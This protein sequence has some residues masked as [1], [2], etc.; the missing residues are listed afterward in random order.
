[1][2]IAIALLGLNLP[3]AGYA[4]T[5]NSPIVEKG[6]P[7][8]EYQ[9]DYNR[10][11]D[12][13]VN[14]SSNHKVEVGFGITDRWSTA[15][16]GIYVAQPGGG[17]TYDRF[18]WENTY[19]LFDQGEHWLDAGLYIE[20]QAP[21]AK[22]RL[23]DVLEFQVLLQKSVAGND[24]LPSRTASATMDAYSSIARIASSLPGMT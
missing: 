1:M 20:Y 4:V 18:Q 15:V 19:Q 16:S 14:K 11:G 17:F 21:D 2:L 23:P 12:P 22:R 9:M 13:S 8:V 7:E 24:A 10:D 6:R 5:V 3:T